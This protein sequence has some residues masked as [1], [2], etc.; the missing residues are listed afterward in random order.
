MATKKWFNVMRKSSVNDTDIILVYDGEKSRTVE[1]SVVRD[2]ANATDNINTQLE[3]I[4]SNVSTIDNK[5]STN[6]SNITTNTSNIDELRTQL[7]TRATTAYV[8]NKYDELFQFVSNGKT[9]IASAITD[10]GVS[11]SNTDSFQVMADNIRRI[12]SGGSSGGGGG[13]TT[14]PITI[15][16]I[17]DITV[18]SGNTFN[19]T[20]TTNVEATKHE[21]SLDGG[22]SYSIIYPIGDKNGYTYLHE[23]LTDTSSPHRRVI[24]VTDANNNTAISNIFNI[25]VNSSGGSGGTQPSPSGGI[26]I[27]Q[28]SYTIQA[29]VDIKVNYTSSVALSTCMLLFAPDYSESEGYLGGYISN[30]N[31]FT[32]YTSNKS[33]G[34]Y[35]VK[36]KGRKFNDSTQTYEDYYSNEFTI[37]IEDNSSGGGSG[38]TA[39]PITISNID[40]IT[41]TS[42]NIFNI[43]YTTNVEATKHEI[44]LDGGSSFNV[45]HPT[46]DKN[47]YTYQHEA[48]TDT[49][50]PHRRVIR[51]TDANNNTAISNIFNITVNS[52]GGSGGTQ[53][54]PSGG[55][56][57]AQSSYTIQAGV[58]IKVNYTSSV[59]LSTC[60]LLF[61][62]DYSESE[63]Y[64]GGYISNTNEFT[65]YTSNKSA[66]TYTVK[67]K[68]RKMND[69]TQTYD[70][71]Y[72]DEFTIVIEDGSSGG[73]ETPT[74]IT[75]SNINDMT[76]TSG[77]VFNITYITNVDAVKHEMSFDGGNTFNVIYPSGDKNG[78]VYQHEGITET[79]YSH[80][81]VIR[82]TDANNN[83]AT[84][85]T[86]SITVNSSSSGGGGS[87]MSP[88]LASMYGN[89]RVVPNYPS[90]IQFPPIN[91]H[92]DGIQPNG[93]NT[94]DSWKYGTRINYSPR[95]DWTRVGFWGQVYRQEGYGSDP[96]NVAVEI[97]DAKLWGWNGSSWV[98]IHDVSFTASNTIFYVENFSGDNNNAF[99]SN[100]KLNGGKNATAKFDSVNSGYMWHPYSGK[101]RADDY[102][103][104]KPYYYCSAMSARLVKWNESGADNL[105]SAKLCFNVGGDFWHTTHETWQP[106]WSANGEYAQGQFI[107]CTREWR[108][109]YATNVPEGWTNGFPIVIEDNSGS[110]GS[111]GTTT[112][113]TISNI[114]DMTVTSGSTFNITYT[115]NI[116]AT[117]HE[118]SFD[119]GSTFN[120]IYPSG[121][122]YGYVYQHEAL[123]ETSYPHQR[124]IRV[125]DA[126]NNVATSNTFSITVSTSGGSGGSSGGGSTD[127]I[128]SQESYGVQVGQEAQI[129]YTSSVE[130]SAC[131]LLF[132]PDYNSDYVGGYIQ[133]AGVFRFYT[134]NKSAGTYTV[135][136]KG[137]KFNDSTQTYDDYYSNTFTLI[138]AGNSSSGG[139]SGGSGGTTTPITI[140]NINNMT[141]ASGSTF[142][143][144][145]TT[146]V[147]AV[148][149]EMSF[150]GGSTFN[151]IYPSGDMY[152]YVYQHE[153]ITETAYSHQ[154]VV[155]V[156]D[157][158]GNIATSNT[159]SI[160]VSTSGGSGG[161]S[162]TTTPITI[163]N[164]NNM[165]VSSGS[166][167]NITYTTNVDATTHEMSFDGGSTFHVIHPT[168]N[169]NGYIYQ[170]EALTETSYSHQRVVR[171]TDSNGNTATSNTFSITVSTSGG[172]GGS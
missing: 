12:T 123:T 79:A 99:A 51:V 22:S 7:G 91:A 73:G 67:V 151:V 122:M 9:L 171:V 14:T 95:E 143:I 103:L 101:A 65:F 13:E 116:N 4:R 142:N 166:V 132:A 63:G 34:T 168:G 133:S 69:S 111:G 18:T 117:K 3:D 94:S 81:R 154:R 161:S 129:N 76:V 45:I 87:T 93:V 33:A 96:D 149:H 30:T 159:F 110:G 128:I 104:P 135:K 17:D 10:M 11:T 147:N 163:S 109:A 60:M 64:L 80:Q 5:V 15:S 70:D 107:K 118:M 157:A 127:I 162:G 131:M 31:E 124:I 16:N 26:T 98:L 74:P 75:I 169:K 167:F 172:S 130:L 153:G 86:F 28:S 83:T 20:Y 62:P 66:G 72:S 50:S 164:I 90:G 44:S 36:V 113:I 85:N 155:R 146:N 46:G 152:G 170:H 48:L 156:T 88:F 100:K 148:R 49:S 138:I 105:D 25:T 19:I 125:T 56:T 136:V 68:G 23:A 39:T 61:A 57:I 121:D 139:D 38:E 126:N 119:G 55:I 92:E 54:S 8:N 144:V 71:Y 82:V 77:S 52:S 2:S 145:Y 140:S 47:G 89:P 108:T 41:V 27:A 32:F 59:A 40:D 141:V 160:T 35:T 1:V 165:T 150:D 37:V 106:D 134:S 21:I 97:K 24:R 43:T 112:P 114:D 115:T 42:G 84:S 29:G 53:P 158:N 58:D 102:G 6:T 137:R 78:Y 120:V